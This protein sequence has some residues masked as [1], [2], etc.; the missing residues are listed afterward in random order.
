[1][2]IFIEKID[3]SKTCFLT[4]ISTKIDVTNIFTLYLFRNSRGS[5]TPHIDP[6]S[7][8][9]FFYTGLLPAPAFSKIRREQANDYL[10]VVL[11]SFLYLSTPIT[12]PTSPHPPL[13]LTVSFYPISLIHPLFL[14]AS[15][16]NLYALPLSSGIAVDNTQYEGVIFFF[17][18]LLS[19]QTFD[20]YSGVY[21]NIYSK[22]NLSFL[23]I[24]SSFFPLRSAPLLHHHIDWKEVYEPAPQSGDE[25]MF[26][27]NLCG[28]AD[29]TIKLLLNSTRVNPF[30]IYLHPSTRFS[31]SIK[32]CENSRDFASYSTLTAIRRNGSGER[33]PH[34]WNRD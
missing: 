24:L 25:V 30:Y 3:F 5:H 33:K 2:F 4:S 29:R 17:S 23:L 15:S 20:L 32:N 22:S 19:T 18:L 26:Q 9:F 13:T 10:L 31:V 21:E 27:F 16:V 7:T 34:R 28:G 14:D 1:M 12:S 6:S 11:R 8:P